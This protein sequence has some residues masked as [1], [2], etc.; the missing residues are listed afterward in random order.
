MKNAKAKA[1]GW[2]IVVFFVV[3]L[4]LGLSGCAAAVNQRLAAL[5]RNDV[6]IAMVLAAD[7]PDAVL[8]YTA[9]MET[10]PDGDEGMS[11]EPVGPLSAFQKVRNLRRGITADIPAEVHRNCAVLVLDAQKTV[12]G[13]GLRVLR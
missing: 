3:I 9:I 6:V 2:G 10:F 12:L 11:I 4:M 8:C 5:T 13:L 1:A 7:D